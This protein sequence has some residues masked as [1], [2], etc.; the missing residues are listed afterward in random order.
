MSDDGFESGHGIRHRS[1]LFAMERE[2]FLQDVAAFAG[3]GVPKH[4]RS[5]EHLEGD[6]RE[7][8]GDF[9]VQVAWVLAS[10][11]AAFGEGVELAV[12]LDEVVG[13]AHQDG[14]KLAVAAAH[15]RRAGIGV[16]NLVALVS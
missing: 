7:A 8:H 14:A 9:H 16:I 11:F 12:A 6:A 3:T 13:D 2:Q 1:V 5:G 10:F 15:S 4:L